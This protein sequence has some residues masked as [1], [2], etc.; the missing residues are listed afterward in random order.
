MKT[1]EEIRKQIKH[2]Q[3][4]ID[5]ALTPNHHVLN[6]VVY[7]LLKANEELRKE[8]KHQFDENGLCIFCDQHKEEY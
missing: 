8:C 1:G 6:E 3:E 2:N 4:L 7:S 5:K